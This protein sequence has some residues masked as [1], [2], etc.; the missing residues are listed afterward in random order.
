[1]HG[2]TQNLFAAVATVVYVKVVI[3][4]CDAGVSRKVIAGDVSRKIVHCCAGAWI[5]FWPLFDDAHPSWRLNVTVPA[6]FMVQLF[7]KGYFIKDPNDPDVRSMSRTGD[8]AELLGGP[9]QFTIAMTTVGLLFYKTS[10]GVMIM[11]ALGFGDG[12]APLAGKRFPVGAFK[13]LGRPKTVSGSATMFV[14]TILGA[15]FFFSLLA[16]PPYSALTIGICALVATA[17]E[18]CAPTDM[19]NAIIPIAVLLTIQALST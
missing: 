9:L 10:E 19:D 5:M 6:V 13:I 16:V 14:A 2:L 7:V 18:A 11:A 17:A 15:G 8:P 12:L 4:L 1:M 3:F